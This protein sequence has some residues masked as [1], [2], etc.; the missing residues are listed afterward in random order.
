MIIT[1]QR[2]VKLTA[3]WCHI[4]DKPGYVLDNAYSIRS[5]AINY[6]TG[7]QRVPS[8]GYTVLTS[9]SS[10]NEEAALWLTWSRVF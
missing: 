4:A 3:G 2:A 10:S 1:E 6:V 5:D 8:G 9:N 7:I